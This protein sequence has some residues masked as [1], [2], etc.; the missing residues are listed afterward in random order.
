MRALRL[1]DAYREVAFERLRYGGD[2]GD[3]AGAFTVPGPRGAKQRMLRVIASSGG[4]WDHVS[5]SLPDRCPTWA[6]MEHVKRLFFR[7]DET[8]MQLHVPPAEHIDCCT[9]CLHLWRPHD[10]AIPR[11][12]A[13]MVAPAP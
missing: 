6:E 12:P 9:Y 10:A 3:D 2:G 8:A 1:L 13:I 11:P 7:D 4:G 5:V